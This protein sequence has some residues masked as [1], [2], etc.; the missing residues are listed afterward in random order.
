MG[1]GTLTVL[2]DG[3]PAASAF[4]CTDAG[5]TNC[6]INSSGE[7]VCSIAAGA[8]ES[9]NIEILPAGIVR[10][11]AAVRHTNIFETITGWG[12]DTVPAGSSA[13]SSLS[14]GG[15]IL[16]FPLQ[17]PTNFLVEDN[18]LLIVGAN[19]SN[20]AIVTI[21]DPFSGLTVVG[22][23]ISSN[24]IIPPG[25]ARF[26]S[27]TD[28][29]G[30][31]LNITSYPSVTV[32]TTRNFIANVRVPNL[33]TWSNAG[34]LIACPQTAVQ[35]AAGVTIPEATFSNI[36]VTGSD[37]TVS[38]SYDYVISSVADSDVGFDDGQYST[39]LYYYPG[40]GITPEVMEADA[41]T[42]VIADRQG[43]F[44]LT[45]TVPN[46]ASGSLTQSRGNLT[47]GVNYTVRLVL[48]SL[49]ADP[50]GDF[51]LTGW[52]EAFQAIPNNIVITQQPEDISVVEG[53]AGSF[54][55]VATGDN[56]TYQ[57]QF[58]DIS[59]PGS[60]FFDIPDNVNFSGG[61]TSS[62]TFTGALSALIG[63]INV[64]AVIYN[65]RCIISSGDA[66]VTSALATYAVTEQT[67]EFSEWVTQSTTGGV[68]TI[69][70]RTATGTNMGG[71]TSVSTST[72]TSGGVR[73]TFNSIGA[74]QG[75]AETV[76][77]SGTC[78]ASTTPFSCGTTSPTCTTAGTQSQ[79]Y[80]VAQ[81]TRTDTLIDFTSQR[82]REDLRI[83]STSA[84][85]RLDTFATSTTAVLAN[86]T[87]MCED[88]NGNI[89]TPTDCPADAS[90]QTISRTIEQSPATTGS[91]TQ[92]T[93]VNA[94]SSSTVVTGTTVLEGEIIHSQTPSTVIVSNARTGLNRVVGCTAHPTNTTYIPPVTYSTSYVID[95][96]TI[97]NG[98]ETIT[99][100]GGCIADSTAR[101][102]CGT[103]AATCTIA[104]TRTITFSRTAT[105]ATENPVC[106][107]SLGVTSDLALCGNPQPR[108]TTI[109][110]AG[111]GLTRTESCS[112]GTYTNPDRVTQSCFLWNI[113]ITNPGNT[114][115]EWTNCDGSAGTTTTSRNNVCA[116]GRP[117]IRQFPSGGAAIITGGSTAC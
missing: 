5:I 60:A 2:Q 19:N 11:D 35:E 114:V 74:N 23:V 9:Y 76:T 30:V 62:V 77:S 107:S 14:G 99:E 34:E 3:M 59:V 115:V 42:G 84:V 1:T 94:A 49:P 33:A 53:D 89:L 22:S 65:V 20:N 24:G 110:S 96:S 80:N 103:T 10:Y 6:A 108:T 95:S 39:L 63:S 78:S 91:T 54:S 81:I 73:Q 58:M 93:T 32:A 13:W 15:S 21:G 38:A 92:L 83:T 37:R 16:A 67:A 66:I 43:G 29:T 56:L 79:V 31:N 109:T 47:N 97:V 26:Y 25:A 68:V 17:T 117:N 27:G 88:S 28:V 51:T 105:T 44:G 106:T 101:P 48:L 75:G 45:G 36:V 85:T 116:Q 55:I 64:F 46:T 8:I 72:R 69:G 50:T 18:Q 41:R 71:T 4:T 87:R 82:V 112:A 57:W 90:G 104:G 70:A 111:T 86:Q 52:S 7:P 100:R 113:T 102:G 40:I 98:I 61:T 12:V